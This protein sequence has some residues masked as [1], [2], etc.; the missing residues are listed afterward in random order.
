MTQKIIM[1]TACIRVHGLSMCYLRSIKG[2]A[3][4]SLILYF[5]IS[6]VHYQFF[7]LVFKIENQVSCCIIWIHITD[8]QRLEGV[9]CIERP[10]LETNIILGLVRKYY[11][12]IVNNILIYFKFDVMSWR[13]YVPFCAQSWH[14]VCINFAE[15]KYTKVFFVII[16]IKCV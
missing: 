15:S 9:L 8:L 1:Y 5:L 12:D 4:N 7:I 13:L 11:G 14:H 6:S 3:L 16:C 10:C 2:E